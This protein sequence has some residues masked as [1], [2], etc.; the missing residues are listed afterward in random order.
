MP[1]DCGGSRWAG[2]GGVSSTATRGP[3]SPS[4]P[5]RP[6]VH[7]FFQ[8]AGLA[9]WAQP[10]SD[11]QAVSVAGGPT[12]GVVTVAASRSRAGP[13]PVTTPG[14]QGR[15][16]RP[17][18]FPSRSDH[19]G[20]R[21]LAACAPRGPRRVRR[22]PRPA[23]SSRAG[24]EDGPYPVPPRRCCPG[25]GWGV[26]Y[27]PGLRG[28]HQVSRWRPLSHDTDL[29]LLDVPSS[30]PF[31]PPAPIVPQASWDQLPVAR[32]CAEKMAMQ[33]KLRDKE[34]NSGPGGGRGGLAKLRA[35]I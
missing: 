8:S 21:V 22:R 9:W 31:L 35:W 33:K 30:S 6:L 24:G 4:R 17:S 28:Q 11:R 27:E 20:S 1:G 32:Q 7:L 13:S 23:R 10:K 3:G 16:R 34:E 25:Q 29:P 5:P 14:L 12:P 18:P 26:R 15:T 2:P 19:P